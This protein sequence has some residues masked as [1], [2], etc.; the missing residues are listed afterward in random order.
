MMGQLSS[1][2]ERLFYSFNI[3]DHI[4]ANHLLRS[5]DRCLDLSDLR[6]YLADF[7]SPIG[8][9]SID[10]ELMI[11]LLV[12][13][14]CYGIRSERRLCEEAH[15]NLAYRWFCRLS[16]EDE[17][18]NHSTF[19]KNRHGR[20]RDSSLF[21]WLFNEVLRRCM[22]AGLVKGEGFAVDASVIKADASRQRGVPGDDEINWRDP[23]LSTRAV[24][25]YLEALDE[26]ALG[27]VLPK[28]LSVTDPLSRWTAAPGGP[29]FFAYSTN[30]LIDVEHGVIMDVEPTPAHRT[31]EVESTKTMIERVEEQFDIKPDRLI[32]DT[33]YGT[34]PML[35]WMVNE[36]DI[37][38]HVP[39][40]DKTERK[41]ESLSISD[42]QWS[43]E[44]QEYRCPTGHA[45]RSEWRAFKNQRSHVTKADTI[46]FRSRQTDCSKCSMKERCCPNTSFRKIARSVHE[47]ARN[48]ARRI[49]ATPQYVCSRHERKKVE[50]LFAHLKRIL[51]LERLRL[52]GMTG[53]ND[54]FTLAAAVQNL[55][56]LAKLTS[57]GP[58]TTG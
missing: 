14:Y 53:A 34:A 51:K 21:R 30:Y 56:R 58:P 45:L 9:P 6:H 57:Q 36:K 42:F 38:P 33:A 49:A 39:V 50:M 43:E 2:Q 27:E 1:G 28:R 4:P 55:R 25:E 16:L 11:R 15:L 13:G 35:A 32:G 47:A 54:E 48:V 52:R 44:A 31:A 17:V 3:E 29:A 22:D 8:R 41:N 19:S 18:P 46:I 12:V 40:W 37:E 7:Y 26:E 5:I 24:R 23:A 20:F 10:P